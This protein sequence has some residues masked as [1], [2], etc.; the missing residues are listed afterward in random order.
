MPVFRFKAVNQAGVITSGTH[1]A[2]SIPEVEEWL[3]QNHLSPISI[4]ISADQADKV[5]S[6]PG[7]PSGWT[8]LKKYGLTTLFS[9]AGRLPP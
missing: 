5:G 1:S 7:K 4:E 3:L 2:R 8:N 9:F 6:R